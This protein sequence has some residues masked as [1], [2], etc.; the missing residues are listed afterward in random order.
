MNILVSPMAT[1]KELIETR[2]FLKS[3]HHESRL[4]QGTVLRR[5]LSPARLNAL[6][7]SGAVLWI[8]RASKR[9]LVD[10][11]ASKI[12]GGDDG[13]TEPPPSLSNLV[14]PAPT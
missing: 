1:E 8:E 3:I 4:R 11:A 12:V 6:A 14:L 10:E 13:V 2:S 7:Q 5:D 9:K